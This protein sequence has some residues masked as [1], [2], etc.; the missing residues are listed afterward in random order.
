MKAGLH[1]SYHMATVVCSCG[2]QYQ[3]GST[4]E[5]MRVDV[6]ARCHPFWTGT[7]QRIVDQGRVE[8]FRQRQAK[9]KELQAAKSKGK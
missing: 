9:A 1:P 8:K 2:A 7:G 6:C 3:V 4:R 5:S